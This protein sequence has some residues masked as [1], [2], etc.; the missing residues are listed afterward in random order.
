MTIVIRTYQI[1]ELSPLPMPTRATMSSADK[2]A[3]SH[4]STL[5]RQQTSWPF[6]RSGQ[7]HKHLRREFIHTG[8]TPLR[9]NRNHLCHGHPWNLRPHLLKDVE[10]GGQ[11]P[12]EEA[13]DG[14]V[15]ADMHG[16]GPILPLLHPGHQRRGHCPEHRD[17]CTGEEV[18]TREELADT[19]VGVGRALDGEGD[20]ARQES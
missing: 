7:A 12:R 11:L 19:K 16:A 18:R 1:L 2:L 8:K 5:D 14:H 3:P 9:G 13:E 17:T 20:T 4:P 15:D 6:Q 10:T